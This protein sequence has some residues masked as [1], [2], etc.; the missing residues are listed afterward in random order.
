MDVSLP[1]AADHA[2]IPA[3]REHGRIAELILRDVEL[4]GVEIWVI[5]QHAPRQS[6]VL[7]ADAEEAAKSHD[8][9]RDLSGALIDHDAFD[10]A[11]FLSITAP[12]GRTFNF[13]ACDQ[14]GSFASS[15]FGS[16]GN[17]HLHLLLSNADTRITAGKDDTFPR[18]FVRL[19]F[20]IQN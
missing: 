4:V 18:I 5:S 20:R 9:I 8:R 6:A 10:R 1:V 16:N 3:G 12:N 2:G 7:V 15:D 13:V 11:E 17:C 19:E 14:A